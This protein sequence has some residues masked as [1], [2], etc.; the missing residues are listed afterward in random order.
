MLPERPSLAQEEGQRHERPQ[1]ERL[2]QSRIDA[3]PLDENRE[4]E[5]SEYGNDHPHEREADVRADESA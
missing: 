3:G 1:G 5:R 4:H 2:S